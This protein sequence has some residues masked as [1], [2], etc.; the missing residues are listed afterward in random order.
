MRIDDSLGGYDIP[1]LL[2]QVLQV[3]VGGGGGQTSDIEV[4]FT[5]TFTSRII[6]RVTSL[7]HMRDAQSENVTKS[8]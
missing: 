3:L 4:S 8:E 7:Q 6:V 5:Q 1:V 2:A